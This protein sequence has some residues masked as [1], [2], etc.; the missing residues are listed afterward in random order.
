[1]SG[2][3]IAF[4]CIMRWE[5]TDEKSAFVR[6]INLDRDGPFYL[7]VDNKQNPLTDGDADP[8]GPVTVHIWVETTETLIWD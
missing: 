3:D 4:S 8:I 5:D 1:M 7:V 6:W 2:T